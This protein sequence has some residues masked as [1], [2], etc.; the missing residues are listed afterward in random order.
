MPDAERQGPVWHDNRT[1]PPTLGFGRGL[2]EVLVLLPGVRTSTYPRRSALRGED[3]SHHCME[4]FG[5]QQGDRCGRFG[6]KVSVQNHR[7]PVVQVATAPHQYAMS[8]RAGCESIAHFLRPGRTKIIA[9]QCFQLTALEH[10]TLCLVS[11]CF[12]VC[13]E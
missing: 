12:G 5:W 10:S 11:P 6:E 4:T 7:G 2:R 9:R 8:T 13:R 1:S 3:G